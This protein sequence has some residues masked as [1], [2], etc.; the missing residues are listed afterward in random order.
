MK[1]KLIYIYPKKASFIQND[2]AFLSKK[3]S[4]ITQDLE[5]ATPK[6]LPLN[7]L[8]QFFF[9]LK[10]IHGANVILINFGGYFSFLPTLLGRLFNVPAFV[11]LNGTDCVSF[12]NYNYG[13]LRK[14]ILKFFIKKSYQYATKLFP[15]DASLVFQ[16]YTFEKDVVH[17]KQGINAFFPELNT[18]IRII[19]NGFD[20]TFWKPANTNKN[21]FLTVAMVN[22]K[23]TFLVKGI[24]LIF[25]TAA[26]FPS[27]NFTIIG[28]STEMQSTLKEVPNNIKMIPFLKK[29]AL[30][31][32]YQKHQYYLQIS[33]NEG[34]GCALA[35]AML[36]GCIP[37]VT[38]VG[39]LPNVT[40]NIGF[41]VFKKSETEFTAVLIV[42]LALSAEEKRIISLKARERIF[43]NFDIS[44]RE[45]LILQGIE[46]IF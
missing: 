10:N 26:S 13:S 32:A 38:N 9:L 14:P 24:D 19:P 27:E 45:R 1:N 29:E 2:I 35:E 33:I 5:W 30:K 7:F 40:N 37:I 46:N 21:G 15:V 22:N 3:Y 16:K 25:K 6:K 42:A 44:N 39:A 8:K 28:I 31:R 4:V 12:P 23:T 36:C 17:K 11:I 20:T 43:T 34:F 41:T 18:S